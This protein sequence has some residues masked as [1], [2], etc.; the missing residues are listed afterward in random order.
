[1][2]PNRRDVTEQNNRVVFLINFLMDSLLLN[3]FNYYDYKVSK[4]S[5]ISKGWTGNDVRESSDDQ[6]RSKVFWRWGEY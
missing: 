2:Q 5:V 1:M 3:T 4:F 6:W